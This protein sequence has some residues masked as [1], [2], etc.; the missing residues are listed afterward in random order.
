MKNIYNNINKHSRIGD[1]E[2]IR[3]YKNLID[4]KSLI[5][6][7]NKRLEFLMDKYRGGN[8]NPS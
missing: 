5:G 4:K 8:G 7:A 6:G 1:L 2:L 3:F